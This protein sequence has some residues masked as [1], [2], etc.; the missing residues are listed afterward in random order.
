MSV[1]IPLLG[2]RSKAGAALFAVD[3]D[4]RCPGTWPARESL[5]ILPTWA[6]VGCSRSIRLTCSTDD[7]FFRHRRSG[8][9]PV[10][11]DT[12]PPKPSCRQLVVLLECDRLW[13]SE[14]TI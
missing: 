3:D 9:G 11:E 10:E 7:P 6:L 8:E 14:A 2:K 1:A 13:A 5:A 4:A 12:S